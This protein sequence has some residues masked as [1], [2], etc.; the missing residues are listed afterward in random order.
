MESRLVPGLH[1]AGEVLDIQGP[2]GGY[3]LQAAFATGWL[4]AESIEACGQPPV[5]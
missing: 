3:N 1:F 2:C 4:A 5:S